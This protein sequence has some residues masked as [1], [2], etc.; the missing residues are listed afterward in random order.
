MMKIRI[1]VNKSIV[2]TPVKNTKYF[3]IKARET[4][5][6]VELIDNINEVVTLEMTTD[7][8]AKF[9]EAPE[10]GCTLAN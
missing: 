8:E 7:N 9:A 4:P 1:L 6:V 5:D 2:T 3:V 10:C